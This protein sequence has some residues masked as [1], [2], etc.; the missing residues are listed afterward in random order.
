MTADRPDPVPST[1][2]EEPTDTE[3]LARLGRLDL[4]AKARLVTGATFW[5]THPEPRI[6][7]RRMVLSDGPV[8]V[9]GERWD[10]REPSRNLP[11]PSAMAATWDPALVRRL[12]ALLAA[13]ARRKQVDVL[14]APTINLHRSPLGGRHFECFSEDPRLTAMIATAY[15]QG[16]QAGGLAACAKHYVANDSETERFTVDVVVDTRTLHEVYLAPF[17][18]LVR[19]AGVW[20]VMA[21]YNAVNGATMTEHALLEDPLVTRWGSDALV[22]SDWLALRSTVA[23]GRARID[24]AM[25]GP[26]SPWSDGRL[27]GAVREGAVDEEELDRKLLRLLRLASRVGALAGT[28]PAVEPAR[29]PQAPDPAAT[30]ALLTEAAAAGMVLTVNRDVDGAGPLLPLD[31]TRLRRVAVLGP[32]AADARTQGGGS[33]T[34]LPE[35]VVSPLDGLRAALPDAEVVHADGVRSTEGLEPIPVAYLT[36][37]VTGAPGLRARYLDAD[38]QV[39]VD[40]LR[41]A[42][43][44]VFNGSEGYDGVTRIE[45]TTTFVPPRSGPHRLGIAGIGAAELDLDGAP[46]LAAMIEPDAKDPAAALLA[47]PQA[48]EVVDLVAGRPVALRAV[49]DLPGGPVTF[50]SFTL[51]YEPPR[52]SPAEEFDAAVG[53]AASADVAVVV[54]G[55]TAAIESEGYDRATLA[56]PGEQ[57]ALVRAVV[58]AN[59]RT[60]VVVNAGGPVLLP[61]A[62]DVPA[63]LL[64]WFPGER[65]GDALADVLLGH[66]EPGGR[67]P[68]TWPREEQDVPVF[69]T[70]P[71]D[72]TLRYDEGIHVGYRAWLRASG[73]SPRF[74]FGSG[75]GYTT[76]RYEDLAAPARVEAGRGFVVSVTLTNTGTRP[77]REVVQLYA[78][79]ADSSVERPVRWLLGASGIV[80]GPGE[81]GTVDVEVD[82]RGLAHVE[83]DG[84]VGPRWSTEP[85]MFTLHA[86]HD[87]ATP[88]LSAEVDVRS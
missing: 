68:T 4:D 40:E 45:L 35:E 71:V 14:L 34:V 55:T 58:A 11:S 15:V 79:R 1:R 17:E 87:V 38:G 24:L 56:L 77:G 44:L 2:P 73:P 82:G 13:E 51:G 31:A 8:G 48:A 78:S 19:D 81:S 36:D 80:L 37:P 23:A 33:A 75:Q 70:T 20:S 61:W 30:V 27:A 28:A 21:A 53:L 16:C 86:G 63:V 22:M 3:L 62:D 60:V 84:E 18:V 72:G 41:T 88:W 67:M 12:G 65:C 57:D 5:S 43:A 6:G 49:K 54:V 26:S 47:P 50:G 52:R 76:W 64:A 85:G 66:R 9:R 42:A 32:N 46:L 83:A 69:D 25:P 7:L 39:L 29:V 74:A 10:E 59:P